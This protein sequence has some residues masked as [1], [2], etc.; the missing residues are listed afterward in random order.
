MALNRGALAHCRVHDITPATGNTLTAGGTTAVTSQVFDLRAAG[1][2]AGEFSYCKVVYTGLATTA[3]AKTLSLSMEL[4]TSAAS[5]SGFAAMPWSVSGQTQPNG[6][7]STA[8]TDLD[9]GFVAPASTAVNVV[10]EMDVDLLMAKE[11][12][13]VTVT[14]TFTNTIT[15]TVTGRILLILGGATEAPQTQSATLTTAP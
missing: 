3:A 8:G 6:A 4:D 1:V 5:G 15:D 14:G 13:R 2:R 11:F 10:A 12:L 9:H 7:I